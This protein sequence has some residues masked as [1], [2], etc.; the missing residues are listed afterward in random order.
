MDK[1][2]IKSIIYN[3]KQQGLYRSRK[4]V[5]SAQTTSIMVDGI[6]MLNFSSNDYLGL[7]NNTKVKFSMQQGITKYGVGTGSSHLISGHT[8]AHEELEHNFA[9]FF[10]TSKALLFSS[11]YMANLGLLDALT[12]RGDLLVQDKLNHASLID[13]GRISRATVKR[14]AHKDLVQLDNI[15]SGSLAFNSTVVVSDGVFSMDG[16]IAN[17]AELSRICHENDAELIIDEAH[18][19]GVVGEKGR[20]ANAISTL[21]KQPIIM[22][23]CGKSLG[24]AGAVVAGSADL[25]DYLIQ[26]SRTY[27]YTTGMP[28]CIATASIAALKL[29]EQA[30]N[31]R[32]HLKKLISYL[33]D[34]LHDLGFV[35]I[36]SKTPIQGILLYDADKSI[37]LANFL[38]ENK[39]LVAAIRPP[40]VPENTSRLRISLSASHKF[41]DIDKLLE[42]LK[43]YQ[44]NVAN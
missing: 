4:V 16:D 36:D 27:V 37:E 41:S 31:K 7:A 22:A 30:D 32:D 9:K 6:S 10:K 21:V 26:K 29:L 38:Y 34:N 11:G 1:N 42:V 44:D 19:F 35:V 33:S 14:Y 5:G 43:K 8:D 17:V 13:G 40:T 23:T 25:I 3:I 39:I 20:G 2:K 28:A 15:V 24:T 18:G 12:E